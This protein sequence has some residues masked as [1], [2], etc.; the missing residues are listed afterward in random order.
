[1]TLDGMT[2]KIYADGADLEGLLKL[3]EQP[4]IKGFTTN[5]T[6]MRKAGISDYATFARQVLE[7]ITDRPISFEVFSDDAD[8]MRAQ[9][10]E[11]ASWGPNVYVKIPVTNTRKEPMTALVR[12]LSE[13]GVQV[14]VTA[15]MTV[16]QVAEI[17]GALAD[18]APSN[19]SVF[20]GRVADTGRDP[21]PL[22][23]DALDAMADAPRAE[24]IWASPREVLNIIQAN[25]IGCHIITVT[26]DLLGK[27]H[28]LGKNLTQYSLE[29]VR[30]FHDDA[31]AAGYTLETAEVSR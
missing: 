22:M 25:D 19:I 15:L 21:V 20:A 23:R 14:N 28:L 3:A 27:L 6:L 12:E 11:I 29:T 16:R 4:H 31:A 13:A 26:H 7:H 30:M 2:T 5:P 17:A 18:G 10:K 24:L 1:M 9:A 8:G